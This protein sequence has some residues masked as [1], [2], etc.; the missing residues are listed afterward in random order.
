ME[1]TP[2]F[3]P[4]A[5]IFKLALGAGV[6]TAIINQGIGWFRD[7]LNDKTVTDR[8]AQY[9]AVRVAVILEKFA[10]T[11]A[12]TLTQNALNEESGGHVGMWKNEPPPFPDYPRDIDWKY[13][14][15]NLSIRALS[16]ANEIQLSNNTIETAFVVLPDDEIG[17]V[18]NQE[19]GKCGYRAWI[20]AKELR[21]KYSLPT[22]APHTFSWDIIDQLKSNHDMAIGRTK[23]A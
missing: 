13:L 20:I 6:F 17:D 1:S 23:E 5:E 19:I 16:L 22:F 10:I 8:E 15:P 21:L 11:C 2:I 14:E 3:L 7:F 12:G 18:C 4:W 9:L